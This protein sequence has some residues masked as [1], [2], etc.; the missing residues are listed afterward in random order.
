[1]ERRE[2]GR[3]EGR[4]GME[5][6]RGWREGGGRRVR[7]GREGGRREEDGG[8]MDKGEGREVNTRATMHY[9]ILPVL[10]PHPWARTSGPAECKT[11]GWD[12]QHLQTK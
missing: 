6:G 10:S 9:F 11:P 8:E 5:E 1:M 7:K 12:F 4:G 2:G 3:E